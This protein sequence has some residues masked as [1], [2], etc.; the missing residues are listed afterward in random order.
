LA[1]VHSK[2]A[3]HIALFAVVYSCI[4]WRSIQ[5]RS[6]AATRCSCSR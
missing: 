4:G 2:P 3:C 1:R 6:C 5:S